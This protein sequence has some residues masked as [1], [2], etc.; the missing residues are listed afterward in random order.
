MSA[1][2]TF[3]QVP[4]CVDLADF[5]IRSIESGIESDTCEAHVL[6][7]TRVTSSEPS[8]VGKPQP[9]V[10]EQ[11]PVVD[12]MAALEESLATAK[13]AKQANED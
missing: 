3:C 2:L 4:S 5:R 1:D 9:Q 11:R 10:I 13:K 12:L 6:R 8:S 7:F